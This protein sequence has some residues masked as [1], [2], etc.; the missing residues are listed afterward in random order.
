MIYKECLKKGENNLIILV[1]I[2]LVLWLSIII[3]IY[4]DKVCIERGLI[5]Y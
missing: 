3:F 5:D 4:E 1:F 2:Y